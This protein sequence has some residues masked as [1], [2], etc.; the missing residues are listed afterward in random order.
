MYSIIFSIAILNFQLF[1]LSSSV[2]WV[3]EQII[4]ILAG[5]QAKNHFLS[6]T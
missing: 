4:M 2:E 3:S 5:A 6:G 1:S